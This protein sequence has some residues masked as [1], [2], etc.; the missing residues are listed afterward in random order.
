M[1]GS[2]QVAEF[3]QENQDKER[4]GMDDVRSEEEEV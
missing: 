1:N 2:V 3:W 4:D